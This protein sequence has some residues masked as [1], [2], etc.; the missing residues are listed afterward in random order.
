MSDFPAEVLTR[1]AAT[2]LA[3]NRNVAIQLKYLNTKLNWANSKLARL[4][5]AQ[6]I[7]HPP[8]LV[9][10]T[11][12]Q[13]QLQQLTRK[14]KLLQVEIEHPDDIVDIVDLKAQL[15]LVQAQKR[16]SGV[17]KAIQ[18]ER[19]RL[20]AIASSHLPELLLPGS[21]WSK[22]VGVNLASVT[23]KI[24]RQGNRYDWQTMGIERVQHARRSS[25]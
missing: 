3:Y 14:Q 1:V 17:C 11:D 16:D 19:S 13:K 7:P 12:L 8:S 24:A 15:V 20:Y 23:G 6:S 4:Q 5:I 25:C 22:A 10:I 9:T 21:S 18:C 2:L